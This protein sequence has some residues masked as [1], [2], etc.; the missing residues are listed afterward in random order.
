[1]SYMH[2]QATL[3]TG[4]SVM[5]A[6]VQCTRCRKGPMACV[7]FQADD[8]QYTQAFCKAACWLRLLEAINEHRELDA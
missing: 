3:T 4:I 7:M 2:F 6:A 5:S 8:P 1:M